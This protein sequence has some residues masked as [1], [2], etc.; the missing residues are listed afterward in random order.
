MFNDDNLQSI[1]TS[2]SVIENQTAVM[3]EWNLNTPDNIYEIGNYRYRPN[4]SSPT[5]ANFGV[6]SPTF[7]KESS[8]TS[9]PYYYGAT[10]STIFVN[11]GYSDSD[12]A[13]SLFLKQLKPKLLYSL[14]DCFG[15]FR[16]RSGINKAR[17]FNFGGSGQYFNFPN[18]DMYGRPR[19]YASNKD[20]KFKYWSSFRVD[21]DGKTERGIS[22]NVSG[23]KYIDDAAPFIVYK[24]SIPTNRIILKMQTNSSDINLGTFSDVGISKSFTDPFYGDSNKTVPRKWK[25][26]YLD[27]T[28]TWQNAY[29]FTPITGLQATLST[30][31][32]TITLTSGT[33]SGMTI[34]MS[35]GNI[36]GTGAFDINTKVTS[37]ISSSQF[38]VSI[39]PTVN[40]AATFEVFTLLGSDGYLELSYGVTNIP[41][42]Y[43]ANFIPAKTYSSVNLLPTTSI[44]GY[45]YLVK[46]TDTDIGTYYIWSG[47]AYDSFVPTYGWHVNNSTIANVFDYENDL[48]SP[49][50]YVSSGSVLYRNFQYIKGLRIVVDTM[51]KEDSVLD[52]IELSPRLLVNLSDKVSSFSITKSASDLGSSGLPVGQLLASVGK[53][54][55][56]DYDL[57]FSQYNT[58]SILN[59]KDGSGNLITSFSS[60]NLQLKFYEVIFDM[61]DP[62]FVY[63]VPLKTLYSEGFP[64][65]NSS[66]RTVNLTLRDLYL[67]FESMTAPELVIPDVSLSSAIATLFDSIGFTNFKFLRNSDEEDLIIPYFYV[68]PGTSI[69]EVLSQLAIASQSAM[70]FDEDNNFIVMSKNYLM[71]TVT[72]RSTNMTLDG[73]TSQA[74]IIDLASQ[75]DNIFNDGKITYSTKY[76]QKEISSLGQASY[77]DKNKTWNYKPVLL[78][79]ISA[80][81]NTK[82]VNNEIGT[83]SAYALSAIPLNSNLTDSLPYV[84][85]TLTVQNNIMDFGEGVYWIPRYNGYFYANGEIIKY[86]AVEYAISNIGYVWIGSVQ[87][88]Q[89][90]FS[91]LNFGGSI[92]PTGKVRI[93]TEPY[94]DDITGNIKIGAVAKHGRSQFGTGILD[95]SGT[96]LMKPV[97]HYA[98]LSTDWSS[99]TYT[100][101]CYMNSSSLFNGV[102]GVTTISKTLATGQLSDVSKL[103]SKTGIIKDFWN[104][105]ST[106][107][108]ETIINSATTIQPATI[109]SSAMVMTGPT[110][111]STESPLDYIS[112]TYKELTNKYVHYGTRLRIVGSISE[113]LTKQIQNPL[114]ANPY[115]TIN[116]KNI[117][118][119]GGGISV[120]VNPATNVGYYFEISALTDYGTINT[121]SAG[122]SINNVFFY[123]LVRDTTASTTDRAIPVSLWSGL[124]SV[125]IDDGKF[126]GQ[127]RLANETNPTVYDLAVEYEDSPTGRKFYLYM[128]QKCIAVVND[129]DPL[130]IRNNFALFTR[131]SSKIMFENAY[132]LSTNYS[133]NTDSLI[134]AP[135]NTTFTDSSI[136][137]NSSFN[138]YAISGMIQSTYLSGISSSAPP[139]HSIY[140]EEFGTIMREAAYFNIKYDKA[141]PAL[142]AKIAPTFNN[143]KG[144]TV[145]GFTAGSYGAEFLIFNN[146]D[147]LLNLDD[148]SGNYLR[149]LGITFTQQSDSTLSVDDYFTK[150]SDMSNPIFDNGK[151]VNYQAGAT[152]SNIKSNRMIYGKKEFNLSSGYIQSQDA[153]NELMGWMIQKTMT[154]RKSIGLRIFANPTIQLGD[155]VSITYSDAVNGNIISGSSRFVVYSIEYSK[156]G[157]G[158]TMNIYLSEVV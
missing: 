153:A 16:P 122:T 105:G 52:L 76:I 100:K 79:E 118:G 8:S 114:G 154:P 130:P 127:G 67:L 69:A 15:R 147:S 30:A 64:E 1:L 60:K 116:G 11:S 134:N 107:T 39:A 17:V 152:Y 142:Y 140:F 113:D 22:K 20:D 3:A 138:K 156:D 10:D 37:I 96:G 77:I 61:V 68:A 28:N 70:F 117:S 135:V 57:A 41:V 106:S 4:I 12:A 45:A 97:Y 71:P 32:T 158:P 26:Q 101:S 80:T 104:I 87:E 50:S 5:T 121:F 55:L 73:N 93:Y 119:A 56:S 36:S 78:W 111:S 129:S 95:P 133:Q 27:S 94:Y 72:Q 66:D 126:T 35:I 91:K 53:L 81:E 44:T 157:S 89:N 9:N 14:E 19:Y 46:T 149:I 23:I 155:I 124:T 139:E 146:T 7:S 84:D 25:I 31:S 42:K 85:S 24:Y 145:S 88:Y 63:Y 141:Y 99:Q 58:N 123:K 151:T 98:G 86:D 75:T 51:N 82:S 128:N 131:G 115:Y 2:S 90:Y 33:T 65:T 49:Q 125:F 29:S 6:I 103:A 108:S 59:I 43:Q 120:M 112:Y 74:N 137:T 110:F 102:T 62:S 143:V 136:N 34:G 40:G 150:R 13:Q 47:I 48:V 144:Y 83:Q 21:S 54:I 109:Q 38:A 132:A 92:F 18:K 148:T